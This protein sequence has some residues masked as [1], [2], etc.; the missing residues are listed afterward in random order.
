MSLMD[1][2]DDTSAGTNSR[3]AIK[4]GDSLLFESI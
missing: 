4:R 2:F 3:A 1:L